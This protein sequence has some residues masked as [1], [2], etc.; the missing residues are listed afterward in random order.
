VNIYDF[1]TSSLPLNLP[2]HSVYP[3]MVCSAF[4]QSVVFDFF[5]SRKLTGSGKQKAQW[6]KYENKRFVDDSV[7]A[8]VS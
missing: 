1:K 6:D 7:V 5:Q 4:Y 3:S 8:C 2:F